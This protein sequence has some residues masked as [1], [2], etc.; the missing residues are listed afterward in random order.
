MIKYVDINDSEV[1]PEGKLY[2]EIPLVLDPSLS[3]NPGTQFRAYG[4]GEIVRR[5]AYSI[6]DS[7]GIDVSSDLNNYYIVPD[8]MVAY[9]GD[10]DSNSPINIAGDVIINKVN[11]G[12]DY[13]N[14]TQK[15]ISVDCE[16][17]PEYYDI[18]SFEGNNVTY[19]LTPVISGRTLNFSTSGGF[20]NGGSLLVIWGDDSDSETLPGERTVVTGSHTY[21]P[22]TYRFR[23]VRDGG[24]YPSYGSFF[25]YE[26][27]II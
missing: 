16:G 3:N 13:A 20:Y 21:E 10:P 27:T 5:G 25:R 6:V 17:T 26:F 2:F 9:N 15:Y 19:N 7:D 18:L 12:N 23:L 4:P 8:G 22:G 1:V 14:L 11:R 24:I